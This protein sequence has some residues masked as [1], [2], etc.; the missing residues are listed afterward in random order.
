MAEINKEEKEKALAAALTQIHK[1]FGQGAVMRL[2]D[3]A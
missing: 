1:T 3:T 2:G